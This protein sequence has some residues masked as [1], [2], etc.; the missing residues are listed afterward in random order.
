VQVKWWITI[1]EPKAVAM[2]YSV[3]TGFAPNILTL[4]HGQYL[5][6]HTMLL[7]HAI[8][9]RLYKRE[10]KDKQGGECWAF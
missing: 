1:N 8:A 9:Y 4:G 3:A 6:M 7:S 2:G 10:F 5:A